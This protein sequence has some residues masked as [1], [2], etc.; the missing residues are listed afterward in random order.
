MKSFPT[1][2]ETVLN[3]SRAIHKQLR[4]YANNVA[5]PLEL[6]DNTLQKFYKIQKN[7][8]ADMFDLTETFQNGWTSIIKDENYVQYFQLISNCF[9]WVCSNHKEF[10]RKFTEL[11]QSP[12]QDLIDDYKHKS[13]NNCTKIKSL[14]D[15]VNNLQT[16]LEDKKDRYYKKGAEIDK[17]NKTLDELIKKDRY[18]NYS[19]NEMDQELHKV[20]VKYAEIKMRMKQSEGNYI[21]SIDEMNLKWRAFHRELRKLIT[22]F[23]AIEIS[24]NINFEKIT[25]SMIGEIY[26]FYNSITVSNKELNSFTKKI[27]HLRKDFP[28]NQIYAHE[29]LLIDHQPYIKENHFGEYISYEEHKR[30]QEIQNSEEFLNKKFE[31]EKEQALLSEKEMAQI[32]MLLEMI[33]ENQH[34]EKI[35]KD[36]DF[37]IFSFFSNETRR[38]VFIA[39]TYLRQVSLFKPIKLDERKFKFLLIIFQYVCLSQSINE[40]VYGQRRIKRKDSDSMSRQNSSRSLKT[41]NFEQKN[42]IDINFIMDLLNVSSKL[43]TTQ[44]LGTN[45]YLIENQNKLPIWVEKDIWQ[46]MFKAHQ[47]HYLRINTPKSS[48]TEMV[49]GLFSKKMW[50]GQ[51]KE[52][53]IYERSNKYSI[54]E[55]GSMLFKLRFPYEY[56]AET[57]LTLVEEFNLDIE[58]VKKILRSSEELLIQEVYEKISIKHKF[59]S[60]KKKMDFK[61]IFTKAQAFGK[62]LEFQENPKDWIEVSQVN[63]NFYNTLKV[64]ISKKILTGCSSVNVTDEIRRK[65]WPNFI[66]PEFQNLVVNPKLSLENEETLEIINLDVRRTFSADTDFNKENLVIVLVNLCNVFK[67]DFSYYQ[68]MNYVVAFQMIIFPKDRDTVLKLSCTLFKTMISKY[69]NTRLEGLK[70]GFYCLNRLLQMNQ[71]LLHAKLRSERVS[72]DVFCSPWFLTCFSL[73]AQHDKDSET[74]RKIWDVLLSERWIGFYKVSLVIMKLNEKD[75]MNYSY[76][77]IMQSMFDILKS[78]WFCDFDRTRKGTIRQS[79]QSNFNLAESNT[80]SFDNSSPSLGESTL[81]T[82]RDSTEPVK[83]D[84]LAESIISEKNVISKYKAFDMKAE[85]KKEKLNE[86]LLESLHAE[87]IQVAKKIEQFWDS[88][89]KQNSKMKSSMSKFNLDI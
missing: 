26:K 13:V 37:D 63:K 45:L 44:E 42:K 6:L 58:Y 65:I 53:E 48:R 31:L 15:L 52:T 78:Q 79:T 68:G 88:Y 29:L 75:I 50:F 89:G 40:E 71:P 41:Q 21:N 87:Y 2:Q 24:K 55:V 84:I 38:K 77:D 28:M 1:S 34:D 12:L 61:S 20:A 85:V 64:P 14:I 23:H 16:K 17:A 49:M 66:L 35:D 72:V 51:T 76:E 11:Y 70:A 47:Q 56:I 69:V 57:L 5:Q 60:M 32:N 81:Y 83:T 3:H 25:T 19:S 8:E 9:L 46:N 22:E 62:C 43:Y 7:Y 54:D 18:T 82:E 67:T 30:R 4:T 27:E 33:F 73:A 74:L 59:D 80:Q 36:L 10:I 86:R 39:K